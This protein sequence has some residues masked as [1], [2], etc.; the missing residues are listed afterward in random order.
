MRFEVEF[1]AGTG[2]KRDDCQVMRPGQS[3]ERTDT[4]RI[5][6]TSSG[7][8]LFDLGQRSSSGSSAG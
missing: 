2:V 1:G 7:V 8:C 4:L 6:N 5:L 3:L